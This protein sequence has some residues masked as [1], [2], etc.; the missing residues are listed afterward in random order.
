MKNLLVLLITLYSVKAFSQKVITGSVKNEK[1]EIV[2][3]NVLIQSKGNTSIDGFEMTDDDGYFSL[4]YKGKSDSVIISI[5]GMNIEKQQRTVSSSIKKIDFIVTEKS[6]QLKE[7]GVI[8]NKIRRIGDTINYNVASYLQQGDRSIGDILKKLPGI[9]V[10]ASGQISYLGEAINKFYIENLDMLGGRYGIATNNI[11]AKDVES[12]QVLENHQPVKALQKTTYSEKTAINLKLKEAAKGI[13]TFNA[14][15]GANYKPW[16]WQGELVAMYFGKKK[17]SM[18]VYKSNNVG[19]NL[20]SEFSSHYDRERLYINPN[21]MLSVQEPTTPPVPLKRYY[22]NSS[23]AVSVNYL[24]KLTDSLELV[25]DIVYLYDHVKQQ[26]YSLSKQYRPDNDILWI[27]E[28]ANT[29]LNT[30]RVE[31]A[32]KLNSN[33]SNLFFNNWLNIKGN[34]RDMRGYTD[35]KSNEIASAEYITQKLHDQSYGFDNTLDVLKNIGKNTYNLYWAIAYI[36]KPSDLIVAPAN[37]WGLASLDKLDQEMTSK[38]FATH[39]R[40]NYKRR[41]NY[42]EISHALWGRIDLEHLNSQLIGQNEQGI[43]ILAGDS[44]KNDLQYNTYQVGFTQ[45]YTYKRHKL[46]TVLEFPL[47][48]YILHNNDKILNKTN[49]N[50]K[51]IFNPSIRINY[52]FT[53][54]WKLALNGLYNKSLGGISDAYSGYIMH[55]YRNF[56]RNTENKLYENENYGANVKFSY[57]NAIDA[58]FISLEGRYNHTKAN[59]IYGYNYDGILAVKNTIDQPTTSD[60]YNLQLNTSKGFDFWTTTI[61]LSGNYNGSKSKVLIQGYILDSRYLGYGY[62]TSLNIVPINKLGLAYSLAWN[63]SHNYVEKQPNN[64]LKI[65]NVSHNGKINYYPHK[66]LTFVFNIEHQYNSVA[67]KRYTTFADAK[68]VFKHRGLDY[69]FEYNNIFN[70]K[71]YISTVYN[72]VNTYYYSYNLRPA[73]VLLNIRFNMKL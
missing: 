10:S 52:D 48:V 8:P 28:Y 20:A 23:Q 6:I 32:L 13:W 57:A 1:G 62:T 25:T 44:L 69:E 18:D 55:S 50:N 60:G 37:Y 7:V 56:L 54:E 64:F 4:M 30:H 19:V 66:K 38:I 63:E 65:R 73:S 33:R 49:T 42:L 39:I 43:P 11:T 5:T 59:L 70:S 45:S 15:L 22:D 24:T 27:E 61:R 41:I 35:T 36:Q 26:G 58:Y 9:D 47:Y 21:G 17:Q 2:N 14:L 12:V 29:K 71:Q 53:S 31:A 51:I 34:F 40:T 68:A 67:N 46:N 72:T 16:G 3:A